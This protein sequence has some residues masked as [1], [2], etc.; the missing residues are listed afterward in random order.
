MDRFILSICYDRQYSVE[1]ASC[2][3]KYW[4]GCEELLIEAGSN[5]RDIRDQSSVLSLLYTCLN[6]GKY[7]S[8]SL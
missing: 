4:S 6:N 3:S 1:I 8:Y 5:L 7:H 2:L